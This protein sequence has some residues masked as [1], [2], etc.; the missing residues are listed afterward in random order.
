MWRSKKFIIIA[1][2]T[3]LVLGGTLGGVA[4]AQA[5]DQNNDTTPTATANVSSFLEKVAE[6]YQNNTGVAIDPEALQQ[7]IT[8]A[9]QA[10][11]DEALDN[12]LDKLVADGTITQEQA[13]DF[14]AWLEAKPD[15]PINEFKEWWEARPDI[16]SMFGQNEN[17]I[18]PFG[19]LHRF[20]IIVRGGFGFKFFGWCAPDTDTK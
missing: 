13:E 7:A 6:I 2:M 8:E 1:V 5:D 14:K 20:T 12:Y 11:R 17:G 10:I 3:V 4:I 15:L 18:G 19:K 16:S 9:R